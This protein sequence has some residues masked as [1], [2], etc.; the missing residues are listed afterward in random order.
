MK[1]IAGKMMVERVGK[2]LVMGAAGYQKPEVRG[3][4]TE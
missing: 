4:K 2:L 3:Q 1:Q